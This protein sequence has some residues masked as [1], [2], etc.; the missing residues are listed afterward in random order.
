M[1]SFSFPK[2][3]LLFILSFAVSSKFLDENHKETL[4]SPSRLMIAGD[5]NLHSHVPPKRRALSFTVLY[6][7]N[8][9]LD[10]GQFFELLSHLYITGLWF[11][12]RY[13]M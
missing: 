9:I 8:L 4:R 7:A 6:L 5:L 2:N 12:W 13:I 1:S 3:K 11:I 10:N